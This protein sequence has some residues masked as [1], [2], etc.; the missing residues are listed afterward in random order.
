MPT[1]QIKAPDGNT[2]RI[3]GPDGATD[4]Q[5]REQVL[6]Q[7]PNASKQ[8]S[9]SWSETGLQ[10]LENIP[11]SAM[12]FGADIV[13]PILHPIDTAKSL[14]DLGLGVIE[15][16]GLKSGTEHEKYADAVGQFLKD[17]YGGIEN[18]KRTLA[19]D[20]VGL[21][22]DV[23]MILTGGETAAVRLPGMAGRIGEI[24]GTVGRAVDPL[25]AVSAVAKP[26]GKAASEVLGVTTG[27]GGEPLRIAFQSGAE[28][29]KAGE[30]FRK[31]LRGQAP[32][33]EAV[34]EARNAVKQLRVERGKAYR[35]EM[36]EI[37]QD[38]TVLD[39]NKIDKAVNDVQSV[40]SYKGQSLSPSTEKIRQTMGEAI[41]DW[42]NLDPAEFHTAEGIDALKQKLG[43]IRDAAPY[44]T[45]ERVVADQIYQAVRQTIVDQ[46]PEYAKVMKG[47]EEASTQIKEIERTLSLNPNANVDTALR[48]LQSTLRDNVNTSF[49]RREELVDFLVNSGAPHLREKLAGQSLKSWAPRGLARIGTQE[50]GA[51]ALGAH[52]GG[53]AG[54]LG[55]AAAG[56]A[57]A[58]PRLMGEAAHAAGRASN[59]PGRAIGKAGFQLG[60][61]PVD[62]ALD[63][64]GVPQ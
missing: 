48:K 41:A 9:L 62:A 55:G 30:E 19:N 50:L 7:H 26:V 37:G 2:Y 42:K 20:P 1:Y 57:A 33:E 61:D 14:K 45:P 8:S 52:A 54:G 6:Q 4:D 35:S 39:F 27:A 18:I 22:A 40:K 36:A 16:L 5:V 49:G 10:A 38:K 34:N 17:R 63:Q 47:Y 59:L 56:L 25:S 43:D 12:K 58:S 24:A 32:M 15:H 53:L 11:S 46:V 23:S 29:G 44:G 3:D 28:G 60:R 21:A 13:Q 31:N 64:P 51:A